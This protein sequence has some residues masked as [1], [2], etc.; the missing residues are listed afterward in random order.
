[1]R[2]TQNELNPKDQNRINETNEL[3]DD[4]DTK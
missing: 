2:A 1:M 4:K 3:D